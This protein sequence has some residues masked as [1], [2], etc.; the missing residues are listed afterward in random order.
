MKLSGSYTKAIIFSEEVDETT[1]LQTKKLLSHPAFTA[2][3]RIMPDA[4]SG[5]GSVIGFTMPLTDKIIP[6]VIGVDIGCGV[7]A[8]KLRTS[9]KFH[10]NLRKI[11][12]AIRNLIPTGF[13]IH[14]HKIISESETDLF[15]EETNQLASQFAATF[16]KKFKQDITFCKP[17]Y[18]IAWIQEKLAEINEQ[19]NRFWFSFG[20]LGGGN[21]FIELA[22]T[23]NDNF[24]LLIHCGSRHLGY[25]CCR[26]WQ[27]T[28]IRKA[29]NKNFSKD[30]AY[31]QNKEAYQYLFDMIFAQQYAHWN[32][33]I[34]LRLL[35]DFFG[36]QV[37]EQ[38]ESVHNYIDFR[39][40]IM[41]K[42]AIRSYLGEKIIVP[43]HMQFGSWIMEGKSNP[44]WNFSAPH[45]AG[46]VLSRTKAKKTLS[47][48]QFQKQ[49]QGIYSSSI[50][51]FTL[52]EAPEAY[53]KPDYIKKAIEP[54]A[55]ILQHLTPILNV[56]DTGKK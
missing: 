51:S 48:Q 5:K 13:S 44:E 28:A 45:G 1:Y 52:D 39:D 42:G 20:T 36:W 54:T 56:K 11:D 35:C 14:K 15:I 38:I 21:H 2:P 55:T 17:T 19:K 32:R 6:N 4:H 18:S 16:E 34:I 50:N 43:L 25:N 27:E 53:K 10:W 9:K 46:R 8:A 26:F 49:M 30:L 33:K 41:R 29:Y 22:Q 23:D 31:L 37:A 12:T 47:L 7:I 24:W 40:L 3:V